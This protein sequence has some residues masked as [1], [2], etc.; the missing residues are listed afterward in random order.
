MCKK[1]MTE[2][3]HFAEQ[4]WIGQDRFWSA[5]ASHRRAAGFSMGSKS[6]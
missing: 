6:D 2:T 3:L 4:G 1:T 5:Q